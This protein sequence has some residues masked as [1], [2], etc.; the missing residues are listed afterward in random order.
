MQYGT[1]KCAKPLVMQTNKAPAAE[2]RF[3]VYVRRLSEM[4]LD[5]WYEQEEG[6]IDLRVSK[7]SLK[8]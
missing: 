1:R 5:V 8:L 4:L 6:M 7:S 2:E 3:V